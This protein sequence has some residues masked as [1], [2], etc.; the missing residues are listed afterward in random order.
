[1]TASPFSRESPDGKQAVDRLL[2]ANPDRLAFRLSCEVR[3]ERDAVH[4]WWS[5]SDRRTMEVY[6]SATEEGPWGSIS[7]TMVEDEIA[8]KVAAAIAYRNGFINSSVVR[9]FADPPPPGYPAVLRAQHYSMTL[10]PNSFAAVRGALERTVSENPDYAEAW[11]YLAYLYTDEIRHGYD[12]TRSREEVVALARDAANNAS[13]LA[14]YS[15]LTYLALMVV[16][17]VAGGRRSLR[18]RR[19]P[20]AR[21]QPVGSKDAHPRRQPLLAARTP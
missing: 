19:G 14:P 18:S 1:M 16:E 12:T 9:A 4:L 17:F 3:I 6:R 7:G 8:E 11:A 20:G 10:D 21:D 2:D 13:R 15:A 5:L